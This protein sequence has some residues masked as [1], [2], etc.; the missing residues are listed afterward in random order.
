[1]SRRP[2]HLLLLL[3]LLS[4]WYFITTTHAVHLVSGQ[5]LASS[6]V[7][8]LPFLQLLEQEGQHPLT[9]RRAANFRLLANQ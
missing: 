2:L 6:P 9:G 4:P 3:L 1:M 5:L 8:F 7:I